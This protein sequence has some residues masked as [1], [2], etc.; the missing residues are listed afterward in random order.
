VIY[1]G[2]SMMA[3]WPQKIQAAQ[4]ILSYTIGG[5]ELARIRYGSEAEDWG[6]NSQPCHD[7]SVIKGE[8]HVPGCDAE[9]CP[10]CHGQALSCDCQEAPAPR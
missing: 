3:G 10:S 2:V 4:L 8:F 6:A 7:C 1:R 9:R 5:K